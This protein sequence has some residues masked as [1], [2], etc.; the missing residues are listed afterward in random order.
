MTQIE[1]RFMESVP[2]KLQQISN[3]L[4]K[5]AVILQRL[6]VIIDQIIKK[7]ADNQPK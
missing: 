6:N 5:I 1:M 3:S 2:N 4:E 7:E